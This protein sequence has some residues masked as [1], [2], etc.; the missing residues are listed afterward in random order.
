[1]LKY[2]KEH[3]VDEINDAMDY[4]TKALEHKGTAD[5]CTFYELGM[6]ELEHANRLTHIFKNTKRPAEMTDAEYGEVQKEVLNK[7][8]DSM[9]KIESMKKLYHKSY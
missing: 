9:G 5:G 1:M 6:A 3:I 8:V 4:M 2:L 7:F